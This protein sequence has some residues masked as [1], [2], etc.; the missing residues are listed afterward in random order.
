MIE[1]NAA[2][3][4]HIIEDV[5][6]KLASDISAA[7]LRNF[8]LVDNARAQFAVGTFGAATAIGMTAAA[9]VAAAG[10][11]SSADEMID[12]LWSF[13]RPMAVKTAVEA[14]EAQPL[15]PKPIAHLERQASEEG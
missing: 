1:D 15:T 5:G 8:Q 13:I 10:P 11:G 6:H 9:Y 12:A 3:P 14:I 7:T 2:T 4:Q